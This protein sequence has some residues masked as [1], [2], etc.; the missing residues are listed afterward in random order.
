VSAGSIDALG[1]L[2]MDRGRAAG[3][4]PEPGWM[5]RRMA[6]L[7]CCWDGARTPDLVGLAAGFLDRLGLAE[8]PIRQV[9]LKVAGDVARWRGHA[10]H[11]ARHHA[12]TATNAMVLTDIAGR[13]GP[14]MAPHRRALLLASALAHDIDYEPAQ[15]PPV[16][17]AAEARSARAMD[18][19]GAGCGLGQADIEA[20]RTLILATE[21][22]FRA[23]LARLLSAPGA[24]C[25]VPRLVR[26]LAAQPALA[27]LAGVLSDADLLSSAG[28]TLRW[29]LVQL[30][31]LEREL[32]RPIPPAEDLRFFERI[33]GDD[34][35][36][37][38]GQHF[39]PNLAGIRRAVENAAAGGG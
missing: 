16:R 27:E 32:G 14:A 10:Y 13:V 24:P 12:E 35:L 6:A 25:D 22:G 36:S 17:F 37:P 26:P 8:G 2:D 38:G 3:G 5:G 18:A 33:V 30:H 29:H 21:P 9:C 15:D 1:L 4:A 31:R 28:L 19:I 20:V 39:R 23:A 11:S 7:Y 34:F